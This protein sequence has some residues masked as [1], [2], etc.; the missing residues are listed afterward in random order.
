MCYSVGLIF[1]F[2]SFFFLFES[3]PTLQNYQRL[4]L[5]HK[6]FAKHNEM[7]KECEN[8]KGTLGSKFLGLFHVCENGMSLCA[9]IF[10]V[11]LF[12]T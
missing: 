1:L 9:S 12:S 6:A 7:R 2:L 8:G 3:C 11:S 5:M 10:S 4:Q